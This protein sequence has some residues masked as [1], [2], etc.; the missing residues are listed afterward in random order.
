[1]LVTVNTATVTGSP[2]F[3]LDYKAQANVTD[4]GTAAIGTPV[5]AM[6][7]DIDTTSHSTQRFIVRSGTGNTL[8]TT[9][10]PVGAGLNTSIQFVN[11]DESNNGTAVNNGA[12]GAVD[13]ALS[14]QGPAGFTA[15]TVTQTTSI[16]DQFN[17]SVA[18]SAPV[19]YTTAAGTTAFA[20]ACAGGG[21]AVALSDDDDGLSAVINTPAGFDYFGVATTGLKVSSNG[22]LSF[23][24]ALTCAGDPSGF[25][26]FG[27]AGFPSA[28]APNAV[29]A[30][31]WDDLYTVSVC[32]KTDGTK[33]IIQWSGLLLDDDSEVSFQAILDGANDKVEFVYGPTHAADGS[34]AT[35]GLENQTGTAAKQL[36]S[37]TVN[38]SPNT[39]FTPM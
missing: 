2:T 37:N 27:N 9:A 26:F 5:T 33:L 22:F 7:K 14:V 29:A 4:L 32:Q 21:S 13:T 28:N 20:D 6:N 34:A 1:M 19:T 35:I 12:V 18:A 17:V 25:C 24:T 10:T 30:P 11:A 3:S 36:S 15:F 23:D 31:Y 8:T 16:A 38:Q 39:I